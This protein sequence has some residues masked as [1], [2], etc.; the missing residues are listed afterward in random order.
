MPIKTMEVYDSAQNKRVDKDVL[1]LTGDQIRQRLTTTETLVAIQKKDANGSLSYVGNSGKVSRGSYQVTFD[2]ANFTNQEITDA[3]GS[4]IAVGMTGVGLRITADLETSSSDI[5]IG[6]LL[7]IGFA[8]KSGNVKGRLSFK[9]FGISNDKVALAV[10]STSVLDEGSIQ[11][12]FEAA[13]TVR[14]FFSLPDTK[15]EPYLIGVSRVIPSKA[16]QA[17]EAAAAKL[18]K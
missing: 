9:V 4:I 11:K 8:F 16:P 2:Y 14:T 13:A 10:P 17:L 12:S 3:V 15:L 1:S 18:T 7:P 6:G 5:D